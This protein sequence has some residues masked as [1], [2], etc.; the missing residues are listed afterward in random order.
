MIGK[1]PKTVSVDRG[2][3]GNT[4]IGATQVQIPKPFNDKKQTKY[5]QKKL[6]EAHRKRAAIE[7]VIGHLKTDHRLGRNFYKG[8]IG[9]NINIMLAAAAF[10]FKRMMNKWK[11][12]FFVFIQ[13]LFIPLYRCRLNWIIRSK[14]AF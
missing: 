13:N 8:I 9:D 6:K 7:P 4:Q 10:N 1:E 14:I 5:Q 12:S 11:S 3:R 2:Y